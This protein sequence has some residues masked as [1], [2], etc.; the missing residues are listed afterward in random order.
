MSYDVSHS[1]FECKLTMRVKSLPKSNKSF[2]STNRSLGRAAETL[3]NLIHHSPRSG[4]FWTQCSCDCNVS[5]SNQANCESKQLKSLRVSSLIVIEIAICMVLRDMIIGDNG[6]RKIHSIVPLLALTHPLRHYSI[7]T[8]AVA[9][10]SCTTT[11]SEIRFSTVTSNILYFF[12][13]FMP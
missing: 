6:A 4:S 11:A 9:D 1:S 8:E 13:V 2:M 10:R 3:P 7:C 12:I 5:T